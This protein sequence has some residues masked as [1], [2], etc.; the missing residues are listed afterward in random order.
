MKSLTNIFN[1]IE[2]NC[3]DDIYDKDIIKSQSCK[4][5]FYK[6]SFL[7]HNIE[8]K[9]IQTLNKEYDTNYLF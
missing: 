1:Q 8:I 5:N 4:D 3:N 7:F 2:I 6:L 9:V